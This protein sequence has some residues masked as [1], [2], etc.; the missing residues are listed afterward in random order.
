VS[1]DPPERSDAPHEDKLVNTVERVVR[2]ATYLRQQGRRLRNR[3]ITN[4]GHN[5]RTII[6]EELGMSIAEDYAESTANAW[7]QKMRQEDAD[8]MRDEEA[9]PNIYRPEDGHPWKESHW[10]S[11]RDSGKCALCGAAGHLHTQEGKS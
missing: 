10:P 4:I 9:N 2:Y 3:Q 11:L 6:E 5:I 1:L 7:E 8:T